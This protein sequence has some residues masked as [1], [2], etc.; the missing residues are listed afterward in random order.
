MAVRR[1]F[2]YRGNPRFLTTTF[3]S[4]LEEILRAIVFMCYPPVILFHRK[5][6]YKKFIMRMRNTFC[7]RN[8]YKTKK[9]GRRKL[10]SR[11]CFYRKPFCSSLKQLQQFRQ[12]IIMSSCMS[13]FIMSMLNSYERKVNVNGFLLHLEL[14]CLF[15]TKAIYICRFTRNRKL[16]N[17]HFLQFRRQNL[18]IFSLPECFKLTRYFV[19][20]ISDH[21]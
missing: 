19:G 12:L 18:I 10:I 8:S 14:N 9:V 15:K 5:N 11:D 13:M 3:R 21:Y 6:I 20:A 1:A 17:V 7:P 16:G 2:G 4:P